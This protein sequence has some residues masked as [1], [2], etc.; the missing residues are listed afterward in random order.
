MFV[1]LQNAQEHEATCLIENTSI[2]VIAFKSDRAETLENGK[3]LGFHQL[4]AR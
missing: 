4:L 3:T 1:A 2:T